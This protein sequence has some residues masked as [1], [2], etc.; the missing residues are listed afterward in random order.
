MRSPHFPAQ[1]ADFVL[2][3]GCLSRHS[4]TNVLPL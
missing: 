1:A 3:S 4:H 2:E